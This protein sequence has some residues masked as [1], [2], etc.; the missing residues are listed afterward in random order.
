[1]LEFRFNSFSFPPPIEN[2]ILPQHTRYSKGDRYSWPQRSS[3][4]EIEMNSIKRLIC[5]H[6]KQSEIFFDIVGWRT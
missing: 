3:G 4:V 2:Q 1:V 6:R 5:I